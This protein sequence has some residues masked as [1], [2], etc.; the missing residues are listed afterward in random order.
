MYA[1]I[2]FLLLG[3]TGMF[4]CQDEHPLFDI[5]VWNDSFYGDSVGGNQFLFHSTFRCSTHNGQETHLVRSNVAN[6]GTVSQR[7]SPLDSAS[8][9]FL[10]DF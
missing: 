1:S 5:S 10:T 8:T 3:V 7:A 6:T 4:R 2:G 9:P